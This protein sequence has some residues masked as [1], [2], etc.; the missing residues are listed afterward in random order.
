MLID[1]SMRMKNIISKIIYHCKNDWF[2]RLWMSFYLNLL[3]MEKRRKMMMLSTK[4]P[5]YQSKIDLQSWGGGENKSRNVHALFACKTSRFLKYFFAF[6][7]FLHSTTTY[8]LIL[9]L[10]LRHY[11][12]YSSKQLKPKPG[13]RAIKRMSKDVKDFC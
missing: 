13:P 1:I 4:I 8:V 6:F 11:P 9:M 7:F 5:L 2:F 10:R 3:C 12:R